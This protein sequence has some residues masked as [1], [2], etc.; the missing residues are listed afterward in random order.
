MGGLPTATRPVK[1][2]GR[3]AMTVL[4]VRSKPGLLIDMQA[5]VVVSVAVAC[6]SPTAAVAVMKVTSTSKGSVSVGTAISTGTSAA[7][8]A[9]NASG[10]VISSVAQPRL[11]CRV[12]E[13]V[14]APSPVLVR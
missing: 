2:T 11:L 13:N 12:T 9:A 6:T 8:S 14:S 7:A 10:S 3:L 5:T 1:V 4:G